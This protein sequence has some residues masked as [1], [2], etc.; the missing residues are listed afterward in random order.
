MCDELG[1]EYVESGEDIGIA[2]VV[3]WTSMGS[4]WTWISGT[5]S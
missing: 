4:G 3:L 2:A 1:R 5:G